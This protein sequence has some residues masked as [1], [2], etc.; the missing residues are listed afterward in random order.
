MELKFEDV[1]N[2]TVFTLMDGGTPVDRFVHELPVDG[3]SCRTLVELMAEI[4]EVASKKAKL[5]NPKVGTKRKSTAERSA[6][7]KR[8]WATRQRN[9]RATA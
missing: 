6:A 1:R 2:G 3:V 4:M 9:L 8:A 7:G 5:S